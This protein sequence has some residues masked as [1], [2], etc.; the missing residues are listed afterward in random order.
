MIQ[1]GNAM[2]L[3]CF[4]KDYFAADVNKSKCSHATSS[5][6]LFYVH[7]VGNVI[8]HKV[9]HSDVS[10]RFD[11]ENV[12]V[13]LELLVTPGI[14]SWKGSYCQFKEVFVTFALAWHDIAVHLSICFCIHDY[15]PMHPP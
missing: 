8:Y 15:L 11:G 6:A 5:K 9:S 1:K 3:R 13:M 2:L 12:N 4:P 7:Y 14:N 10:Y